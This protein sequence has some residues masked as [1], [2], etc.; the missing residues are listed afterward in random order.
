[1]GTKSSGRRTVGKLFKRPSGIWALRYV[2]KGKDLRVSLD[3]TDAKEAKRKVQAYLHPVQAGTEVARRQAVAV[4]LETAEERLATAEAVQNR[5]RL[6]EVWQAFPYD[7]SMPGRG[8]RR[9]LSVLTVELNRM[10]WAKF[11][12]WA[13][14]QLGEGACIEDVSPALAEAFSRQMRESEHLTAGRHNAVISIVRAMFRT[15]DRPDPF[16]KIPRYAVRYES[17]RNIE[18][19][20]LRE[21]CSTA[22]GELRRL[23]ALLVYTGLR[24]GDAATMEWSSLAHG[25]VCGAWPRRVRKWLSRYTRRLQPLLPTYPRRSGRVTFALNWQ[26]SIARTGAISAAASAPT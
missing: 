16:V 11:A 24:M 5:L 8:P 6:S 23:F 13:Q 12:T 10:T 25:R 1:M 2:V 17:R 21:I 3:T 22:T 15:M 26:C 19:D 14:G 4:A 9:R 18:V 20:E 7:H